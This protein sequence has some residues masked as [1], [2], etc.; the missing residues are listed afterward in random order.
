METLWSLPLSVVLRVNGPEFVVFSL[1]VSKGTLQEPHPTLVFI[2]DIMTIESSVTSTWAP[3]T[4]VLVGTSFQC[5]AVV[6][7]L[8]LV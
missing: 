7:G 8:W 2:V 4:H 6:A 5:T 1:E 3:K